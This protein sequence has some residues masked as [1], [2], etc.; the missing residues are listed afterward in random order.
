[1]GRLSKHRKTKAFQYNA[2]KEVIEEGSDLAPTGNEKLPAS[3]RRLMQQKEKTK[4]LE[5]SP[6]ATLNPQWLFL[7]MHTEMNSKFIA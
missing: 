3:L 2:G 5:G 4:Q 6:S 7:S 1:M